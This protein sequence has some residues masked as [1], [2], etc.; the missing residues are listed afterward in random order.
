M[1]VEIAVIGG[2]MAGCGIAEDPNGSAGGLHL[3][4][5]SDV[6]VR[7]TGSP[8][9]AAGFAEDVGQLR[10]GEPVIGIC[11]LETIGFGGL[12]RVVGDGGLAAG[13][14]YTESRMGGNDLTA[15]PTFQLSPNEI[16]SRLPRCQ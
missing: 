13:L 11:Y 1:G 10:P 9:T 4:V 12:V 7:V 14:V 3:E 16:E 6:P 15:E 2:F 8:D 5:V